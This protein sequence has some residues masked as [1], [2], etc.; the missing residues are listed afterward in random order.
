M[1][2]K[3]CVGILAYDTLEV[4]LHGS[5]PTALCMICIQDTSQF[6]RNA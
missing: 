1:K 6:E 4:N 2:T 3:R 5:G